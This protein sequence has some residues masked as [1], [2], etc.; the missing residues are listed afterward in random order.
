MTTPNRIPAPSSHAR[1]RPI[2]RTARIDAP[3]QR[4]FDHAVT[5]WEGGHAA[6][7]RVAGPPPGASRMGIGFR[8]RCDVAALAPEPIELE[9]RRFVEPDGFVAV[10]T[11]DPAL[12]WTWRFD[13]RASRTCSLTQVLTVPRS[14]TGPFRAARRGWRVRRLLRDALDRFREWARREDAL[15]RLRQGWSPAGPRPPPPT[16]VTRTS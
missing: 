7:G 1:P 16:E 4:A 14:E 8:I 13:V 5:W 10:S 6:L 2:R 11:A 9:V 12:S 15:D 3:I